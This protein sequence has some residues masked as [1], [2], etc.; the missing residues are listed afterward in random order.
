M[1]LDNISQIEE[2][3][4]N[5]ES[6][7]NFDET[8]LPNVNLF[9]ID[10]YQ[11]PEYKIE[12][13]ENNSISLI[14]KCIQLDKKICLKSLIKS[15][16]FEY[17]KINKCIYCQKECNDICIECKQYICNECGQYHIPNKDI[18]QNSFYL[19]EEKDPQIKL[20]KY[21]YEINDL[22]YICK[23][24]Y[25]QYEYFCPVCR[26]N[27]CE[28]CKNYHWHINCILLND[29]KIKIKNENDTVFKN[30]NDIV[31][32]NMKKTIR[33]FDD[34]YNE[35]KKNKK[36]SF[37]I[38]MNYS[39]KEIIYSFFDNYKDKDKEIISNNIF[40]KEKSENYLCN[41]FYDKK[42]K[43]YY[44]NLIESINNG[45]YESH[46]KMEEIREYY[47]TINRFN[48]NYDLNENSFYN[49]LKEIIEYFRGQ[50]HH[51]K[52]ML[53]SIN[54]KINNA[55]FKY[56]IKNLN[57]IINIHDFDILQLK[58]I[59]NNF[60]FTYDYELRRKIG[61]L[62][63]ELILLN[64]SDLLE[65]IEENEY[66]LYESLMLIKKKIS[67]I[68]QLEGP[69]DILSQ[70]EKKLKEHFS[71]LLVKAND[72]IIKDIDNIQI[73]EDKYVFEE[74]ETLI[75]FH[76]S[77]NENN[78]I[79]EAILINLFFRLRKCFGII[80]NE[81][82]YNKTEN[83][84]SQIK[85]EI[86][87]LRALYK[88]NINNNN[89]I[90]L[91]TKENE[92]NNFV[93]QNDKNNIGIC[94][95]YFD[96]INKIKN[97]LKF[98]D[99]IMKEKNKNILQIFESNKYIESAEYEFNKKIN[100]KNAS[101]L[102]FKREIIDVLSENNT[103]D[104]FNLLKKELESLDLTKTKEEVLK[105]INNVQSLLD[106]YLTII[107]NMKIKALSY[108]KQFE[109]F[110]IENKKKRNEEL[111]NN[112][113]ITLDKFINVFLYEIHS[114]TTIQKLYMSY[115]INFYFCAQDTLNYFKEIKTKYKN[116]EL[117]DAMK[118]NIEKEKLLE[119]FNSIIQI[120][121]KNYLK[122]EWEKLKEEKVFIENN[123]FLNEKIKEYVKE[124]NEEQFLKDF[125]NIG[126]IKDKKIDLSKPNP[127]KILIKAY[128]IKV[129]IPL[130]I[131]AELKLKKTEI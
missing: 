58:K 44:S 45:D 14:H 47:K 116:I 99:N 42:F 118:K 62:L 4:K 76:Q 111:N 92:E 15:I 5:N 127:Q 84:N 72:K 107:E 6:N 70:Y 25:I 37:N 61:N 16:S 67:Q 91:K 128:W 81:S 79:F 53:F 82:I 1:Y 78:N 13:G 115:L 41:Y 20:K 10:C 46:L 55:Y 19:F 27:L 119:L 94:D 28:K 43:K 83:V 112:P 49:S 86:E 59:C 38:L 69:K 7:N 39:L 60:L 52:E 65:P 35:A 40:D 64:Y 108:I 131:P 57:L 29:Y 124:K 122:E 97:I 105:D 77:N 102:L 100:L 32:N 66:I 31:L 2:G 101:N 18:K 22:Q 50:Y 125:C 74:N 114:P 63:A 9:C 113:F 126:K 75:Q 110:I 30:D 17:N 51:I 93:S 106:E 48:K 11:I 98:D 130:K 121:D 89:S 24:H 80:F 23:S 36:M 96:G 56:K 34:C 109:K 88:E 129:G 90:E 104:N 54:M 12:I 123:K 71:K 26:I 103:Y 95:S 85:E 33:A 68:K 8:I 117:I 3:S 87:K 120:K 21:I 73:N